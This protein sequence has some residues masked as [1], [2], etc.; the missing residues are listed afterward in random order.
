MTPEA[1]IQAGFAKLRMRARLVGGVVM[2]ASILGGIL[3]PSDFFHAYLFAYLFWLFIALGSLALQML[4]HL[5]GGVWGFTIRRLLEA[6]AM[7]LPWLLLLFIPLL[8]GL[9]Y[10]YPWMHAELVAS[11]PVLRHRSGFYTPVWFGIR[12][13]LYLLL[14]SGMAILLRRWSL[15][16]DRTGDPVYANYFQSACGPGLVLYV[17][18]NGLASMDW[19]MSLEIHWYSTIFAMLVVVGQG[20]IALAFAIVVAHALAGRKL[21]LRI[22]GPSAWQDLGGMLMAFVLLWAYMA[23][24]QYIIIWSGDIPPEVSFYIHRRAGGWHY[25]AFWM[26]IGHIFLPGFLLLFGGLKRNPRTL[27]WIAG[28]LFLAQLVN[29]FWTIAPSF[30]PYGLVVTWLDIALPIAIGDLWI[31]AFCSAVVGKSLLPL[32]DPRLETAQNRE[33]TARAREALRHG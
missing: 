23:Y 25:I 14:W 11:D 27:A 10:L 12:S 4:H 24:S 19:M 21:L 9:P 32:H 29:L 16:Q 22:V 17:F 2:I 15:E 8:F 1:Q 33:A 5:T 13:L 28:I 30:H 26:I 18:A 31:G 6:A 20:L 7:T 3:S